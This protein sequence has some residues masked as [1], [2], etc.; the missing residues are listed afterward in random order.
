MSIKR[1]GQVGGAAILACMGVAAIIGATEINK[2][3]F[4]GPIQIANQQVSDLVADILPPPEYVIEPYLE[5]TL[6]VNN[7][8]SLSQRK[9]RLAELQKEFEGR[10]AYW[11][12]S[13]LDPAL[14]SMI[15]DQSGAAAKRFWDEVD[16]TLIPAAERGDRAAQQASYA[17]L[18]DL[19]AEHRKKIDTL[20]AASKVFH[21]KLA[22]NSQAALGAAITWL[23]CTALL[24][25]GLLVAGLTYLI[26]RALNPLAATAAAMQRMASGDTSV[27]VPGAGRTDEIG[28]MAGAFEV[29]RGSTRAQAEN[30]AKQQAVVTE[31]AGALD[32]LAQG[33]MTYRIETPLAAEYESLRTGFN[34][35]VQRLSKILS[36]VADTA[37]SVHSG[38]SEIRAASDDL[39]LR[40]E[41]QAANLEE[42]AAAM[43]QVTVMVQGTAEGA[44]D[45]NRSISEAHRE[46]TE[47]GAV[48]K[49]AVDAMSAIER[50][51]QEI[52]QIINV[53][54]GIAFQTNL[55]AL[56]A[57]VEAARGVGGMNHFLLAEPQAG[58]GGVDEH[59]GVY[60]MEVLINEMLAY[61]A[62]RLGLR[63]HLYGGAN[64]HSGM[65][66]IGTANAEF[67]RLFL[68]RERIPLLRDSLGG[69]SARRVDFRLARG[70]ARCRLADDPA[71]SPIHQPMPRSVRAH[72]DVELF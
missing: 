43:N 4:G 3:R 1:A 65:A 68:D 63:A 57:G 62:S 8:A 27:S 71:A 69:T 19:Y 12:Q 13:N 70:Q 46:A 5:A 10:Y 60:L 2:I 56:N 67:A 36:S 40:T 6:L 7:P 55:L 33:D 17:R 59:Y 54:D 21:D 18:T 47:G 44:T 66:R 38:A 35:S 23:I 32:A 50:S 42:T 37:A 48:V 30:E 72:G 58:R 45:V 15:I 53:I 41:Q 9:A 61:G 26:R 16:N 24:V 51:A 14:K 52:T 22:A 64:M 31:L 28:M 29:F 49:R 34:Q 11:Q 20:V 39:A 25:V